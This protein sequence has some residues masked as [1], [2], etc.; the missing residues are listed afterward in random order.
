MDFR[1]SNQDLTDVKYVSKKVMINGQFVTLYS[2]NG[3]TWVSS[4]EDI[5]AL[6]E[7]LQ[8]VGVTL[9]TAERVAEG[10]GSKAAEPEQKEKKKEEPPAAPERSLS[11]K[12]RV[13]GPKPRPILRQDGVVIKGTPVDPVSASSAVM[14]FSSDLK[15][16]EQKTTARSAKSSKGAADSPK[17]II[18]PVVTRKQTKLAPPSKAAAKINSAKRV[19]VVAAAPVAK[20]RTASCIAKASAKGSSRNAVQRV[21]ATK[22]VQK[23]AVKSAAKK[24]AK[25]VAK[26]TA[27]KGSKQPSKNVS[28]K[29]KS[30]RK[31]ARKAK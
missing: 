30:T 17:K 20:P 6:M 13:K 21:V 26:R 15:E 11:T 14:S 5:P 4:P 29:A 19:G 9:N 10:E 23:A 18:A 12:Y 25:P 8:Q 3:Q 27:A 2:A 24:A 28:K 1:D 22:P 7:R 31:S 16:P